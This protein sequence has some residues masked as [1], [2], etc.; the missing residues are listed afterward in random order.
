MDEQSQRAKWDE[1][2]RQGSRVAEAARVVSENLHL[3][4]M[5]GDALDLACGLGANA[6]ALAGRGLRVS[7]WD[8]SPRAIQRLEER[9]A[10]LKLRKES[11]AKARVNPLSEGMKASF[12]YGQEMI[13]ARQGVMEQTAQAAPSRPPMTPPAS[14]L[15]DTPVAEQ[16][17][18]QEIPSEGASEPPQERPQAMYTESQ[19]RQAIRR[20]APQA[21]SQVV[22]PEA[23]G[24]SPHHQH[25]G[26]DPESSFID[27]TDPETIQQLQ[28]Q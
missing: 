7:A 21:A 16:Q 27:P 13:N 8:L 2:Y 22:S 1:R 23:L 25:G 17:V 6:L 5:R 20:N 9:I 11:S 15:M 14:A 18:S 19:V 28:A 26:I 12:S 10:E 24:Y 3:L 4:P